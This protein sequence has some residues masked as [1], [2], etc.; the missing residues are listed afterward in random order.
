MRADAGPD[1]AFPESQGQEATIS[2]NSATGAPGSA[3]VSDAAGTPGGADEIG[4]SPID[5]SAS[6]APGET[7]SETDAVDYVFSDNDLLPLVRI[8][9]DTVGWL[10]IEDTRIDYPVVKGVDNAFYLDHGFDKAPNVAGA[11]FMDTRNIGDGSDRHTLVYGHR[12]RD[13]SMFRD[14]EKYGE[15]DF[16]QTHREFELQTLHGTFR[17]RV[18]SAYVTNTDFLFIKTRFEENE[19]DEFLTQIRDLNIH[20]DMTAL[21]AEPLLDDQ[22]RILTL[23]TCSRTFEDARFVVHAVLLDAAEP[24]AEK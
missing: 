13:G 24:T 15:A 22:S 18:F 8:N 21:E 4:T 10:R 6:G 16:Y 2:E 5:G 17:Y 3:G 9:P 1:A 19:Y 7:S 12:M 23:A 11:V 14:L 20:A